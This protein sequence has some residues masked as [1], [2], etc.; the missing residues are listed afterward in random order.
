VETQAHALSESGKVYIDWGEPTLGA[1]KNAPFYVRSTSNV[2]VEL[3]LN[4]ANW[5]PAGIEDYIGISWG[6]NGTVFNPQ[7][8]L[9]VTVSLEVS[10]SREFISYFVE[11]NVIAFVSI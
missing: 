8:E 7:Q 10:S 4:V 2:D 11:N 6:Y 3:W 9:L 5:T 1:F